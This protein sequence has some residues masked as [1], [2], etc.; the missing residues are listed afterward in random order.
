MPTPRGASFSA[1]TVSIGPRLRDLPAEG[2]A[3]S[4]PPPLPSHPRPPPPS[5]PIASSISP[6]IALGADPLAAPPPHLAAPAWASVLIVFSGPGHDLDLASR[7]RARGA[8]IHEVDTKLGGHRHDVTRPAVAD[9]LISATASGQYHFIF[10][11]TPCSS[12]SVA[13][14]PQLRSRRS[15]MGIAGVPPEWTRYLE[16]H[17][18]LGTFTARLITAADAAGV[19]WALE[20]PAD[21]GCVSSPAYWQIH[22]DHAPLWAHHHIASALADAR[23]VMRTFAQCAFDSPFQKWT[24]IAHPPSISTEF[25][26]LDERACQHGRALHIARAHGLAPDG[27]SLSHAA[28]AYP[29]AMNDALACAIAQ[30]TLRTSQIDRPHRASAT[31][32]RVADGRLLGADVAAAVEDARHHPPKWASLRNRL[33]ASVASLRAEPFPGDLFHPHTSSKPPIAR[34]ARLRAQRDAEA[35][36]S[37]ASSNAADRLLRLAAGPVQLSQLY[38]D[39]VYD[40]IVIPWLQQADAAFAA[41][42]AGRPVNRPPSITIGQDQ[43]QPWARGVVWDCQAPTA[44]LPAARSTRS[45][46][47]PGARQLD[48]AAFRRIAADLSWHDTDIVSQAGEGGVECRSHCPLDTVLSFH[49]PSLVAEYSAAEKVVTAD[50]A[51]NWISAPV[52]HLPFAPCRILPRGVIMQERARLVAAPDGGNPIVQPY[53]KPRITTDGSHGGDAAVNAG[54]ESHERATSLP[55]AQDHARGLAICDT[56][57]DHII[58]A[59]SYVVDAESAYRFCPVQQADLWTQCFL[60]QDSAGTAGICI[61]R[62]LGFGGAFAP[63][64]FQ[65]IST[66]V[67]AHIQTLHAAFDTT[68]PLPSAAILWAAERSARQRRGELPPC[69]PRGVGSQLAPRYLQVYV[70]D[71]NGSALLDAVAVPPSVADIFI[72]PAPSSTDGAIHAPPG[73]RVHVHAQLAVRGL[74]D[75]GLDAQPAKVVVGD[76]VT[77]LGLRVSRAERQINC[78]ALKRASLLDSAARQRSAAILELSADRA[79][80]DTLVGRAVNLSQVFPELNSVLHGGYAI[81]QSSWRAGGRMGRPRLLAFRDGS[82]AHGAWIGFLDVLSELVHTNSGVSIAPERS[83]PPRDHPGAIT[84]TTDASGIDGVGGYVFHAAH[85]L[86]VWLVSELWPADILFALR[87][88][89]AGESSGPSLSMPAAELFG[90]VAIASVVSTAIGSSP[91]AVH[92]I[93]DCA[94]AASAINS[95]TSGVHQLRRIIRIARSCSPLWLSV[96]IPREANVDADRLSHPHMYQDVADDAAAAG[97]RVHRVHIPADSSLWEDLRSAAQL[98]VGRASN[99][100]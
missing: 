31:G 74:R 80:S 40:R 33:P 71:F 95:A 43:M 58:R 27:R 73:T 20:N 91:S 7:L 65:R 96:A 21:R 61:D 77:S 14:K 62:R 2:D 1:P 49:H 25:S 68:Q 18:H 52:R 3:P 12:Y 70:D 89:A 9:A 45:T 81:T 90:S 36:T 13:H 29:A 92:A 85:P 46:V 5:H 59:A 94:P 79:A 38:L 39:G 56:A 4:P 22:A 64:R 76:P 51:E 97:L 72:E 78:P 23:A 15:P 24:T 99:Q 53:L 34:A 17:N 8:T 84:V 6:A 16:K 50:L 60:W 48:R 86:D 30:A 63:N 93:T 44:C 57:G 100:I 10:V 88:A 26:F 11:A 87:A 82:S 66:M 98:G 28:A 37:A 54:V 69:G 32:G 41:I 42:A 55:R 35:A 75:F 67:A 83:F 19:P 47:F